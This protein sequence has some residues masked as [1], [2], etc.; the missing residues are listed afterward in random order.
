MHSEML[1]T[2]LLSVIINSNNNYFIFYSVFIIT[3][4]S[5]QAD[6]Y[7]ITSFICWFTPFCEFVCSC[8]ELL[9]CNYNII[10]LLV[11]QLTIYLK[12]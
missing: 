1:I 11:L 4:N 2:I 10:S 5:K 9:A 3:V 7:Y 12:R 8:S 6:I